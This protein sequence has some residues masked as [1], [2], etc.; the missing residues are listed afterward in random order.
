MTESDI[1]IL[2]GFR[3]LA[4]SCKLPETKQIVNHIISDCESEKLSSND[5]ILLIE[6]VDRELAASQ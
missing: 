3:N 2:L 1:D 6:S 4:R 5:I